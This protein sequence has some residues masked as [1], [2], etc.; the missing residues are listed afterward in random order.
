MADR[1]RWGEI[2]KQVTARHKIKLEASSNP[3]ARQTTFYLKADSEKDLD[4]AKR[5]LVVLLSPDAR[6]FSF[7][8][9]F[10][11]DFLGRPLWSLMPP[12]YNPSYHWHSRFDLGFSLVV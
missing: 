7:T 2:M 12:I 9:L 8:S 5:S 3:K 10:K 4:K 11:A 1:R 6:N